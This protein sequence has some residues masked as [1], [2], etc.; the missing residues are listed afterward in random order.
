VISHR[1]LMLRFFSVGG[2]CLYILTTFG[3]V[4]VTLEEL[5]KYKST[6]T[7]LPSKQ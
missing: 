3:I 4:K 6:N 1:L 5:G 2:N 7:F